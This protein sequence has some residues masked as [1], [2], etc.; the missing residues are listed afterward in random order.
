MD[1]L[2]AQEFARHWITAWNAH[3][4]D[5]VLAHFSSDAVFTSSVAARIVPESRGVLVGKEEIRAYWR[6]GLRLLPDLHFELDGV[7][8]GVDAITIN[9]SNERGQRVC[10]VLIWNGGLVQRGYATYLE[11]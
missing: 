11:G 4:L 8:V 3:D 2:A 9:Y 10:E 7:Y 6:E 1:P 5:A